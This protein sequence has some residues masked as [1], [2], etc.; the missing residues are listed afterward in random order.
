[1]SDKKEAGQEVSL[2][3]L[4]ELVNSQEGDFFILVDFVKEG[5]GDEGE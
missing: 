2:S 5:S 4:I 1:M 3:E